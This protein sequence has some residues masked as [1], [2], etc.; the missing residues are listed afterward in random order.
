MDPHSGTKHTEPSGL[1]HLSTEELFERLRIA[2][3]TPTDPNKQSLAEYLNE[4]ENLQEDR[5]DIGGN[6]TPGD[7]K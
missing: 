7:F 4:Q 2:N 6:D 1:D 5:I 3:V